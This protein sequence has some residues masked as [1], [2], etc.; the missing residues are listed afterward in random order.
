MI[1][2]VYNVPLHR[3][4]PLHVHLYVFE[5]ALVPTMMII[6]LRPLP[7]VMLLRVQFH[8]FLIREKPKR[9]LHKSHK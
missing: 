1:V 3:Y 5:Y 6:P 9:V 4:T 7:G 8:S 2:S